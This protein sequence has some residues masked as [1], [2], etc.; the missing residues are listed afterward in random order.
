MD[1][2][3]QDK[4]QSDIEKERTNERRFVNKIVYWVV[5]VG[6]VI[7]VILGLMGYR[8]VKTA[9][10]PVDT[11]SKTAIKVKVPIGSSNSEISSILQNNKIVRNATLFN[12]YII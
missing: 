7:A 5:G 4:P 10:E 12:F 1:H 3:D 9:L 2:E 8:Y 6:L 11:T